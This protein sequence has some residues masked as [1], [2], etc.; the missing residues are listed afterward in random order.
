MSKN[1]SL[2]PLAAITTARTVLSSAISS[3]AVWSSAISLSDKLFRAAG[4]LSV[5]RATSPIVSRK[6]TD[7]CAISARAG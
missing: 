2:M 3:R 6:R 5:S 1:K 4:R 7:G